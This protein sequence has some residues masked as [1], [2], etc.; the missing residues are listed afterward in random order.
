MILKLSVIFT[1]NIIHTANITV[2]CCQHSQ[3]EKILDLLQVR[4]LPSKFMDPLNSMHE[5]AD[6][7][8][9]CIEGI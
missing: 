5:V 7:E 1:S 4:D 2:V 8:T 9:P 3:L 6:S